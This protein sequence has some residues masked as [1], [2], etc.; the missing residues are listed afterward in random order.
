VIS[1]PG[2]QGS[3][4]G[5]SL[6]KP[7]SGRLGASGDGPGAEGHF[8]L[9]KG[10]GR[11][12]KILGTG[13]QAAKNKANFSHQRSLAPPGIHDNCQTSPADPDVA[14]I[15]DAWPRLSETI[16]ARIMGIIEGAIG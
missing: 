16:K 14:R 2:A 6:E 13:R 1:G 4:E 7:G 9:P 11:T 15:V 5:K 10:P 12:N 3:I 8:P